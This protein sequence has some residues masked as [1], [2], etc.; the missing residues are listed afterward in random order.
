MN[1]LLTHDISA[2]F[3]LKYVYSILWYF[4]SKNV[5]LKLLFLILR[6]WLISMKFAWSCLNLC[7]YINSFLYYF[8]LGLCIWFF[9]NH[10]FI[11]LILFNNEKRYMIY[12][13]ITILVVIH[14]MMC[15]PDFTSSIILYKNNIY[16]VIQCWKIEKFI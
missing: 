5:A 14:S 2:Y 16:F 6:P 4:V 8:L 10:I 15:K 11:C 7:I 9:T 13:N 3:I 12:K 1:L